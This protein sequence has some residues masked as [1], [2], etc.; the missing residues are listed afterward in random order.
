MRRVLLSTAA[1]IALAAAPLQTAKAQLSQGE[2]EES[3]QDGLV[4]FFN[5]PLVGGLSLM[6]ILMIIVTAIQDWAGVQTPDERLAPTEPIIGQA[7]RSYML[8]GGMQAAIPELYPEQFATYSPLEAA[9]HAA[10]QNIDRQ[11]RTGE[12]MD[13]ASEI[14]ARRA[15][16]TATLRRL[17]EMNRLPIEQLGI[18]GSQQL[19]TDATI[20]AV[21][22]IEE[23]MRVMAEQGQVEADQR[24]MERWAND[25][26]VKWAQFHHPTAVGAY[27]TLPNE[28]YPRPGS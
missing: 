27:A 25:H 10:L 3:F 21:S 17:Q 22:S 14:M 12:A 7:P 15:E 6:A 26:Y 2:F 11:E 24:L 20:Q 8:P 9:Q 19:N 28:T 5:T 1:A 4:E 16:V 18:A 23:L 13:M